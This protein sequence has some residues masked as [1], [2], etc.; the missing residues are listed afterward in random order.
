MYIHAPLN[1]LIEIESSLIPNLGFV[2]NTRQTHAILHFIEKISSALDNRKHTIGVLLDYSKAF[3]TVNHYIL[4]SK[5][6]HYGVRGIALEW[7]RSYLTNRKQYVSLD[8]FDSELLNVTHGVPQGSLLGP[9]LFVVYINDF[10]LSSSVLS[11]IL[12]ADDSSVFFSHENPHILFNREN[13][14]GT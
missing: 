8:G 6:S 3:D 5:L 13:E 7:Y 11:F 12:F 9:L 1:F 14:F 4:L 10:H 2:K